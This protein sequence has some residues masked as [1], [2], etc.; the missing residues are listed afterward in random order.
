MRK[1]SEKGITLLEL[2]VAVGIVGIVILISAT[3]IGQ[4]YRALSATTSRADVED[5][6]FRIRTALRCAE[7]VANMPAPC[8]VGTPLD[9][10]GTGGG[11][12]VPAGGGTLVGFHVQAT[13]TAV[14][15]EYAV[16][17]RKNSGGAL[18]DLFTFPPGC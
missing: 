5:L 8:P 14:R 18:K 7:T 13:C 15:N 16:K 1:K 9:L 2:V 3:L 11:I 4:S 12:L 6:R 10:Y 17:F